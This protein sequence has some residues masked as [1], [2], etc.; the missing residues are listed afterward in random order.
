MH[1]G[2]VQKQRLHTAV[3]GDG[4]SPAG[5]ALHPVDKYL[6]LRLESAD[7]LVKFGFG[8]DAVALYF[9]FGIVGRRSGGC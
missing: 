4:S 2:D 1:S 3:I 5:V 6:K 8:N 7:K 9:D